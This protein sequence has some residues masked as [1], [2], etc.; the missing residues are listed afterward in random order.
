M[1]NL[2]NNYFAQMN[3]EQLKTLT[4]L[5]PETIATNA[6]AVTCKTFTITDLWKIHRAKKPVRDLRFI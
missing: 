4:T 2:T 6:T 1:K 5:A 3:S